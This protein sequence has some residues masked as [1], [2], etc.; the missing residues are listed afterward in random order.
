MSDNIVLASS[1]L[2]D[3]NETKVKELFEM[4]PWMEGK[5]FLLLTKPHEVESLIDACIEMP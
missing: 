1:F 2:D 3:F 4:R 5:K